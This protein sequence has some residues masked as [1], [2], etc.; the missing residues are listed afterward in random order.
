LIRCIHED[1]I[2]DVIYFNPSD[3]AHPIGLNI[4][5]QPQGLSDDELLFEQDFITEAAVPVFRKI[6]RDDDSGGHWI[7]HF[8]RNAIHTVFTVE[9]VTLFTL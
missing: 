9:D 5:E 7:E 1:R 2:N 3:I 6:F 8:L 4:L